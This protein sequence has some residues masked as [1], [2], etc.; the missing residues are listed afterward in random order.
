MKSTI[1]GCNVSGFN[2]MKWFIGREIPVVL[3]NE[4][5]IHLPFNK[6]NNYENHSQYYN[7]ITNIHGWKMT[8]MIKREL[9]AWLILHKHFAPQIVSNLCCRQ[10]NRLI[11]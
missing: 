4:S 3:Q 1:L 2:V 6:P 5:H 9:L 10:I 11:G 8:T 7:N